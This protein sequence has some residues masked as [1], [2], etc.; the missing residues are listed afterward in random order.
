MI[1][2]FLHVQLDLGFPQRRARIRNFHI[3]EMIAARQH[4]GRTQERQ[5]RV[6]GG[7]FRAKVAD[8]SQVVRPVCL[9]LHVDTDT[10]S[11]VGYLAMFDHGIGNTASNPDGAVV[12]NN[13][14]P[15][16]LE[17]AGRNVDVAE[18]VLTQSRSDPFR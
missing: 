17:T 4:P 1:G 12:A 2:A 7:G 18:L 5:S 16:D 8:L 6:F 13:M 15:D 11:A 9:D 14:P 10:L 3:L